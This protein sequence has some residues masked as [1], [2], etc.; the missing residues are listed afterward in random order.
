MLIY[1]SVNRAVLDMVPMH[2]RR[3]LDVGCGG[4]AFGAALKQRNGHAKTFV[5]GLT[6]SEA[7]AE[8]ARG[9]MDEV[10][11]VDLNDLSVDRSGLAGYDCIVC[12]HVLEHLLDPVQVLLSLQRCLTPGGVLVVALPNVLF[13]RQ[14]LQFLK[15][16]FRYTEGG[17]MDHTHLR[18]FDWD[19]AHDLL[20]QAGLRT[21]QSVADGGMPGSRHLGPALSRRLDSAALARY[22]GLFGAQFVFSACPATTSQAYS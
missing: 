11:V 7:E 9:Q 5:V 1:Q 14:R 19:S 17:L 15:G 3:T 12:S 8:L 10:H 6:Y 16:R 4:G 13:W 2:A 21:I 20:S 22:P 18:F